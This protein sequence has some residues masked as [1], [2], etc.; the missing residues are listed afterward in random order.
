MDP[1]VSAPTTAALARAGRGQSARG[2]HR[3][4]ALLEAAADLLLEQGLGSVNHRGV[5]AQAALPL[6]ATTYYF[7]SLQDLRD[8]AIGHLADRWLQR[9]HA[10]VGDLPQRLDGAEDVARA[11]VRVVTGAGPTTDSPPHH[12]LVMYER[13]LEAGRHPQLRPLVVA[14][15]NELAALV[16]EVLR[17]GGFPCSPQ[18]ARLALDVVDGAIITALAEGRPPSRTAARALANLLAVVRRDAVPGA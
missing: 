7:A 1:A 8:Q 2:Q 9:A 17:R 6:A 18:N 5:A 12:L 15:N 14:Y 10:A 13:Y 3:Q 4:A 11:V 16:Q